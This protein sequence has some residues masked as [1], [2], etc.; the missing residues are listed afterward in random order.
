MA[1]IEFNTKI[2]EEIAKKLL[3]PEL[4]DTLESF[5][6]FRF[7]KE[8]GKMIKILTVVTNEVLEPYLDPSLQNKNVIVYIGA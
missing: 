6:N 8:E 5:Q 3:N 7:S 4:G 1:H 2:L